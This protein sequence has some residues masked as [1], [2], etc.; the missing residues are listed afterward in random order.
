MITGIKWNNYKCIGNLELDFRKKDGTPYNTII[1]AGENGSGK[2]TILESISKYLNKGSVNQ[3]EYLEYFID[4]KFYRITPDSKYGNLGFHD[5]LDICENAT[6]SVNSGSGNWEDSI[7]DDLQD[8]RHY[9]VAYSKAR[10][11]FKTSPIKSV[12]TQ[13]IDSDKYE[14]DNQDDFSRIKQLLIDIDGQDSSEWKKRSEMPGLNDQRYCDFKK[15][16][17]GYRFEN[18]FNKFF[19]TLKYEGIDNDDSNEKK[20]VFN[21]YGN[22]IS[23][24]ELSTGEKQIVFRGVHLLKNINNISGGVVLIDELEL[25]MHPKWQKKVLDYYRGLFSRGGVQYVQMIIATHSEYVVRSALEDRDNVIVIVLND[26]GGI[27]KAKKIEAPSVLPSITSAE[28][29]YLAFGVPSTDYHIELYGYL[30][31]KIGKYNITDCDNYISQQPQ[32]DSS[33]HYKPDSFKQQNYKTLPT[34][35]RNAIDHPDSGR[36]YTEEEFETSI[37][38]LINLCKWFHRDKNINV[39]FLYLQDYIKIESNKK[40]GWK[41]EYLK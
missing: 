2:T 19:D 10:T 41:K 30:Q 16:S 26:E 33:K 20:V 17:K 28:T 39:C 31:T 27:I 34:Y 29:N 18:A 13:Q 38:L 25:S 7:I 21:K 32:Y 40:V 23:V 1:L 24:D 36:T 6:Y 4:G 22:R 35:I 12:T 37:D 9:G 14:S 5:R 3:F 8:L 11:G 15:E